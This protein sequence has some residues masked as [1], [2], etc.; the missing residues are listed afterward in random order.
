M[1]K[2]GHFPD[3]VRNSH[4]HQGETIGYHICSCFLCQFS[5]IVIKNTWVIWGWT[6][7]IKSYPF[8]LT[9]ALHPSPCQLFRV[10]WEPQALKFKF[11]LV[12][13]HKAWETNQSLR[14]VCVRVCVCITV[15]ILQYFSVMIW[16]EIS[17]IFANSCGPIT[18][19][20]IWSIFIWSCS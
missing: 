9:V 15:H 17:C 3:L 6:E 7:S 20:W 8:S 13:L 19:C 5:P 16:V 18:P 12:C 11:Q 14:G 10:A 4:D 1:R 2:L